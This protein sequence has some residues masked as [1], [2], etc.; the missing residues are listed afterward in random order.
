LSSSSIRKSLQGL[1]DN[2]FLVRELAV[3]DFLLLSTL[4]AQA[5]RFLD[6]LV[7]VLPTKSMLRDAA[8]KN[9]QFRVSLQVP[10]GLFTDTTTPRHQFVELKRE[11]NGDLSEHVFGWHAPTIFDVA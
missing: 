10:L 3:L 8:E 4:P 9:S 2:G 6:Q 7:D 11:L 1:F 5:D